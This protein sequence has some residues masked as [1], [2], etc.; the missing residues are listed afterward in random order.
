MRLGDDRD[1]GRDEP[2]EVLV[3]RFLSEMR[4]AASWHHRHLLRVHLLRHAHAGS[5]YQ[6]GVRLGTGGMAE[7]FAATM[8]GAEGFARRVAI[9]RVLPGLSQVPTF[10]AMFV[11]EAR[12]A[13]RLSHPNIVS[14]LDLS[15]DLDGRLLL[16]MEYVD[17]KDLASL[18][19]S[20]PIAPSLAIFIA[21]EMLRGLGYAHDLADPGAGMRGVVHRDVSPQNLLLS[22]EGAVKVSDF[23]LAKAREASQSVRSDTVRGKPSYMAPEQLGG[24]PLDG[25]A[26]LYAVGVMLWE[27]LA[28]RSLFAG[29]T[30]EIMGQVMFREILVP[31]SVRAGVPPDL[32]AVAMTLLARDR[33][34]RYPTAEAAIAA[35]LACVDAPRDGRG[36]LVQALAERFPDVAGVR[37]PRTAALVPAAVVTS[38]PH[39]AVPSPITVNA[40]PSQVALEPRPALYHSR[41]LARELSGELPRGLDRRQRRFVAATIAGCVGFVLGIL[42]AAAVLVLVIR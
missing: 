40:P 6:L 18:L 33:E 37:A 28:H 3:R 21:V 17:G 14:V 41:G 1:L 24:E 34:D 35:L 19:E 15:R 25:R 13:S 31:S 22:F 36:E 23:G 27:M 29:T 10:A 9:K 4:A 32:E 7:V 16:V 30:R 26:D 11:A 42:A 39:A 12:I 5:R 20:G 2:D 38:A 8:V